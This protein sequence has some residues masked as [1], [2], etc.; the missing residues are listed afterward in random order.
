MFSHMSSSSTDH[1][2]RKAPTSTNNNQLIHDCG[3][4]WYGLAAATIV[5]ARENHVKTRLCLESL[6]RIPR[7]TYGVYQA[8]ATFMEIACTSHACIS[9]TNRHGVQIGTCLVSTDG[10]QT[11]GCRKNK[12]KNIMNGWATRF[13]ILDHGRSLVAHFHSGTCVNL[14]QF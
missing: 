10:S 12:F 8:C 2:G 13:V 1:H 4:I 11:N 9:Q 5:G 7:Q 3:C 14:T 6:C